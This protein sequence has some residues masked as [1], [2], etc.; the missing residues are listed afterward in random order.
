MC[1]AH[2]INAT[3]CCESLNTDTQNPQKVSS[4]DMP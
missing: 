4:V 3:V 2:T 1:D